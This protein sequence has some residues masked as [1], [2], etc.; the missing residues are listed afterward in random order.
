MGEAFVRLGI[1]AVDAALR[2]DRPHQILLTLSPSLGEHVQVGI[3]SDNELLYVDT[4]RVPLSGPPLLFEQ[5]RR[6]PLYCTSICKLFLA[7]MADDQFS[8][9]LAPMP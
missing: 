3:R 8:H 1:S 6:A 5:G 2:G 7:E 9:W 4:A